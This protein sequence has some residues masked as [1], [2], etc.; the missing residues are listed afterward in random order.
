MSFT[1][2]FASSIIARSSVIAVVLALST[3]PGLAQTPKQS[4]P[5]GQQTQTAG[6][7]TVELKPEPSQP[8]WTKV[9]GK[10][11][12]A[13]TEICY[14]T[15]DFVDGKGQRIL[16][17]A[18]YDVK[19]KQSQKT[20]RILMPLGFLVPPGVRMTVDKSQ[21]VAGRYATCLS[22]G[23][24]AEARVKDDFFSAVKKGSTLKVSTRNQA[25]RVVTFAVP[26]A[27]FGRAF[28]GPPIDPQVLA[29]Q[30]KKM[31]EELQRRSEELRRRLM[32][33]SGSP[34]QTPAADAA[35]AGP[36]N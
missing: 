33:D 24:F 19:G 17:V 31:Q 9:C 22:H 20:V 12:G 15:R 26:M 5:K 1:S 30:Q 35:A 14:T 4:T 32:S 28:D 18:L 27:G 11:Q 36:K 34:A 25:G 16:A 10:D 23:C 8:E 13:K 6:P 7:L 21:P 29:E 2:R 3:L